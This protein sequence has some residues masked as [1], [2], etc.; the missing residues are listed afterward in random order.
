MKLVSGAQTP[1]ETKRRTMAAQSSPGPSAA[2]VAGNKEN[3]ISASTSAPVSMKT[4]INKQDSAT[5][6]QNPVQLDDHVTNGA[7]IAEAAETDEASNSLRSGLRK[8]TN[9]DKSNAAREMNSSPV[10]PSDDALNSSIVVNP[11]GSSKVNGRTKKLSLSTK[12]TATSEKKGDAPSSDAADDASDVRTDSAMLID[13]PDQN[14]EPSKTTDTVKTTSKPKQPFKEPVLPTRRSTRTPSATKRYSPSSEEDENDDDDFVSSS[15]KK[16]KTQMR[17]MSSNGSRRRSSTAAR[18]SRAGASA[19]KKTSALEE[20]ET[21]KDT[22]NGDEGADAEDGE[23]GKVCGFENDY[24]E[25]E[26]QSEVLEEDQDE[27]EEEGADS[28]FAEASSTKRG[29]SR[30]SAAT[31]GKA[32]AKAIVKGKRGSVAADKSVKTAAKRKAPATEDDAVNGKSKKKPAVQPTTST[33][34][35]PIAK[36]ATGPTPFD[37]IQTSKLAAQYPDTQTYGFDNVNEETGERAMIE[38]INKDNPLVLCKEADIRDHGSILT[39]TVSSDG[40][41]LATFCAVGSVKL[42]DTDTFQLIQRLRDEKEENIDEF[43]VGQFTPCSQYM[44]VG[45]KVK[46]RKRWSS[47][48]NDNH[49]MAPPVKVFDI[50]SG[51]VIEKWEGHRE[52]ILQIEAVTFKGKNYYV[53]TSQDGYII[54][55]NVGEDWRTLVEHWFM[56]DGNTCMAFT[57]SFLPHTGNKYF[58]A[59]CDDT[60]RI[61]DFETTQLLQSF[62]PLHTSYLD[63]AKFIHCVDFPELPKSWKDIS[64]S[65]A[66]SKAGGAKGKGKAKAVVEEEEEEEDSLLIPPTDRMSAYL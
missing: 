28:D 64:S 12:R 41:I 65:G 24:E 56:E 9:S 51:E 27:E 36:P 20:D 38:Y 15:S 3:Q 11:S 33:K 59:A 14:E 50:T 44:I 32:K 48:D 63:C 26:Q 29:G 21:I 22:A 31:K 13:E 5:V 42:W 25:E 19:S 7:E 54:K 17:R 61:F 43:Y 8:K 30:G 45:G 34:P 40:T 55:W 23:A 49:I 10:A 4:N 58:A 6:L 16:R 52:E 53:T 46:D 39:M 60:V 47:E 35:K 37:P 2:P 62:E 57:V 66:A 18:G 1:I